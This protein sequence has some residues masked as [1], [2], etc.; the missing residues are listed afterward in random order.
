MFEEK[1]S[2]DRS[3]HDDINTFL[4]KWRATLDV[5]DFQAPQTRLTIAEEF[6]RS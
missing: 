3:A 1:N 2:I 5:V 4:S 6:P